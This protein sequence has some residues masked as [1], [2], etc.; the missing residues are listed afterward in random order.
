MLLDFTETFY[1]SIYLR[2]IQVKL[3]FGFSI[4]IITTPNHPLL[5]SISQ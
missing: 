3:K 4:V 2:Y 1:L 5:P